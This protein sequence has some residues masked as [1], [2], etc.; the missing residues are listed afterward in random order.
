MITLPENH[1]RA[2]EIISR[3]NSLKNILLTEIS[4]MFWLVY[5]YQNPNEV[6]TALGEYAPKLRR[7]LENGIDYIESVLSD[8]GDSQGLARIEA[9][10]LKLESESS[11]SNE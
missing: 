3:A 9:I 11:S 10:K 7:A 6:F 4:A 2:Q 8:F 5:D 1:R